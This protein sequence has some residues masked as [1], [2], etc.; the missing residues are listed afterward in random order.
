MTPFRKIFVLAVIGLGASAGLI[1]FQV[2]APQRALL[3]SLRGQADRLTR[4]VAQA[5]IEEETA[6]RE[7]AS[8]QQE[9]AAWRTRAAEVADSP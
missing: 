9:L 1:E 8:A 7:L 6:R 3:I 2:L 4:E 5:R